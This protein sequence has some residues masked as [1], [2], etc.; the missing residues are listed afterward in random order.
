MGNGL[1]EHAMQAI[2]LA[3]QEAYDR[4]FS[5]V[6]TE[7]L[8]VGLLCEAQ[9][10]QVDEQDTWGLS[11]AR[12]RAAIAQRVGS[13]I[14]HVGEPATIPMTPRTVEVLKRAERTS[15]RL[16]SERVAPGHI[17]LGL[18][19]VGQGE[20]FIALGQLGVPTKEL[21][22]AVERSLQTCD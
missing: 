10:R 16:G 18:L 17:L 3:R 2:Q 1:D 22:Q 13:G 20:G 7:S 14:E 5:H 4:R 8:L 21:R 12:V 19:E 15:E 11:L 6:G 9:T